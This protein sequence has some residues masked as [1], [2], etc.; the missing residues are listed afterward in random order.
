[1]NKFI[2]TEDGTLKFGD[3]EYHRDLIPQGDST[4]HGGGF[5][6]LDNR[7]QII[8]LYGRSYDFGV[9]EFSNL[10]KIDT[11]RFPADLRLP[12]FYQRQFCNEE[13]LE[14][15]DVIAHQPTTTK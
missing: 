15:V 2:I 13:I 5:W 6:H 14:P 1:M 11:S 7:R 12:I 3:V 9:P 8:L 4:C 10:R